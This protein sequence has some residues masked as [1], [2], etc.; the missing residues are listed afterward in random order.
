MRLALAILFVL[1]AVHGDTG[2]DPVVSVGPLPD[3][4]G[5]RFRVVPG[6]VSLDA[7]PDGHRLRTS[8]F[9]VVARDPGVPD[10][11]TRIVRIALPAGAEPSLDVRLVRDT[12]RAG[13]VPRPVAIESFDVMPDAPDP[14]GRVRR[15]ESFDRSPRRYAAGAGSWPSRVA[16]LGDR[17]VFRDQHYVEVHVAPFRFDADASGLRIASEIE[18]DVRFGTGFDTSP[19]VP[20]RDP[21]LESVYRATF[22]NYAQGSLFRSTPSPEANPAP[23][24]VESSLAGGVDDPAARH[25]IRVRDAGVV[26]LGLAR[27]NGTGFLEEPISTWKLTSQGVE[28]PLEVQESGTPNDLLDAAG[29]WVQFWAQPAVED[30]ETVLNTDLSGPIDL[31]EFRDYTDENAYILSI[32]ASGSRSRIGSIDATPT[33]TRPLETQVDG[34]V[35][36]ELDELWRPLGAGDPWVWSPQ[37]NSSGSTKLIEAVIALPGLASTTDPLTVRARVRGS[38]EDNGVAPDHTTR[39][40]LANDASA[41]LETDEQSF[42]GRVDFDHDFTWTFA[43]GDQASDPVRVTVEARPVPGVSNQVWRDF[44]EVDYQR[45]FDV[46]GDVFEFEWPNEDTEFQLAGFTTNDVV[47]YEVTDVV[48]S[49]VIRDPVRLTDPQV[50]GG[51]SFFA[52]RFRV[53]LDGG[54]APGAPRRFVVAGG[55]AIVDPSGTDFESVPP[56]DLTTQATPVDLIVVAHPDLMD[57]PVGC[58]DAA[59]TQ[60]LALRTSQ[61]VT[62]KVVCIQEVYDAFADGRATPLA[63]RDMLTFALTQWPDPKPAYL[64]LLGDA[65]YD[66]KAGTGQGTFVPTQIVFKDDPSIGYYAA[67]N[68]LAIAV[69]G[70]QLADV[71]VGRVSVRSEAEANTVLDKIRTYEEAPAPGLWQRHAIFVSD[72]GKNDD[73]TEASEFERINTIGEDAMKIPPHTVQNLRYWSDFGLGSQTV[74]FNQAIIDAVNGDDGFDGGAVMQYIGH[75]NFDLWSDDV[76]L[77]GNEAS[78]FCPGDDTELFVNDGNLPWLVVHNCL[79]GGFHTPAAK[80][81]GEQW[82]KQDGGGAVAVYAP[83]GLGFRFIGEVVTERIWDELYGDRKERS[84]A[85]PVLNT[86]SALCGQDSIEACQYYVLL[87]DPTTRLQ[88]PTVEP[89]TNVQAVGG[90]TVVD[91]TWTESA[92]DSQQ[93]PITYDVYRTPQLSPLV[94]YTKVNGS[95]LS[96]PSFQDTGLSNLND[97]FYYVVASDMEGFESRLSNFNSDCEPMPPG[98]DCVRAR[99]ENPDP[100]AIP[101]GLAVIDAE[102][103]GRLDVSWDPNTEDDLREYRVYWSTEPLCHLDEM[104]TPGSQ[105]AIDPFATITGLQDGVEYFVSVT[106]TNTSLKES[107]HSAEVAATPTLIRGPK[108]PSPVGDLVIAR[109]GADAELSWSA[110]TTDIYGKAKTVDHY[111]VYRAETPDFEVDPSL[112]I[113]ETV[114]TTFVDPGALELANPNYYYVVRAIDADGFGSGAG[115]QLPDGVL[116]LEIGKS[117]VVTGDLDLTWSAI[118][119][120]VDGVETIVDRYEIY[121]SDQPFSRSDICDPIDPDPCSG[122]TPAFTTTGTSLSLT[123]AAGARYYGVLA[124]DNKGNR[125]PF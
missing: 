101:T 125:S 19:S 56:S 89:A 114:G 5:F 74:A 30:G 107:P 54:L 100:P 76:V 15:Y 10:L 86:L 47:V 32:D 11:P 124:V 117:T 12:L 58:T 27:L 55:V 14:G 115:R 75:G 57:D 123:P 62:S 91:L 92:S 50:T 95:P 52:A 64:L 25:R 72:Q 43:G 31:W 1:S 24:V 68:L 37:L 44:V 88:L 46:F 69:G 66:Y 120:D 39:V 85:V 112:K 96:T 82:L 105:R 81:M 103:G 42:D 102:T 18:I 97:Y 9:P 83:S 40:T 70:D 60:L 7:T 38:N 22:L 94:P 77:C 84:L 63:I 23:A 113:G 51:G 3:E 122:L 6:A 13:I 45:T 21:R 26:R 67:D 119:V 2:A 65:S 35:R 93:N 106:A 41:T 20:S 99:P 8:G 118:A 29:E 108:A 104:C 109:L 121:V 16:W 49:S 34:T 78:P 87:G 61:G 80:S 79:T 33:L 116:D 36:E 71:V 53:D 110:V 28:V 90:N 48:G 111:E 17:G 98:P 73:P 59:L 4:P